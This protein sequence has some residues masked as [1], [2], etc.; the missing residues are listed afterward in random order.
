MR[1]IDA[2]AHWW[3]LSEHDW[4][5]GLPAWADALPPGVGDGFNRDFDV[6]DHRA[7]APFA[8]DGWVHVS[9]VTAPGT[10]LDEAA[11]VEQH[12]AEHGAEIRLVGTVD[13]ALPPDEIRAHLDAQAQSSRFAGVRVLYG[14]E[15]D[16]PAVPVVLEWLAAHD[17][18]LDLVSHPAQADAWLRAL[19]P[20]DGLR[21]VLEHTGWPE[22][23]SHVDAWR[24]ALSR[25]AATPMV[26]KLSGLGMVLMDTSTQALRPWVEGALEAFGTERLLFGSNMP[27]DTMGGDY[28]QLVDSLT[29]LV[30][31]PEEQ[32]GF[33]GANAAAAYGF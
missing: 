1:V 25:F 15:P 26:C 21:V 24:A 27:I 33:W 30:G 20:Y 2:H 5:P 28:A 7:A 16:S 9:A 11:W 23:A 6:T 29:T 8:V 32:P 14:F 31:G 13:P 18:V 3:R 17:R 22:S 12:A 19:A 4:Y 10:Y